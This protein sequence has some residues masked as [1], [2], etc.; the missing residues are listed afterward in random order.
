MKQSKDSVAGKW[1][2]TGVG[3]MLILFGLLYAFIALMGT[4][5]EADIH[6][7]RVGGAIGSAPSW[8]R[9]EWSV[10]Y[11]FV[12]EDG[13][14]YAGTATRRG[15]DLAVDVSGKVKYLSINPHFNMLI[16]E[17]G[18]GLGQIILM[19]VGVVL[20]VLPRVNKR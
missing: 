11:T 8:G 2:L 19:G 9:Y 1:F 20:I 4:T 5:V 3:I 14:E 7:R 15:T 13:Y 6:T 10:D 17:T 16:E 12:A 18:I